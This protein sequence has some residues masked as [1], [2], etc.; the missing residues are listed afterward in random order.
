ML[1]FVAQS[2]I[3]VKIIESLR[4]LALKKIISQVK[5]KKV[6]VIPTQAIID[7]VSGEFKDTQN[8]FAYAEAVNELR[9]KEEEDAVVKKI[10]QDFYYEN[11]SSKK[12]KEWADKVNYVIQLPRSMQTKIWDTITNHRSTKDN[13]HSGNKIKELTSKLNK[14]IALSN[15]FEVKLWFPEESLIL[16]A[17][18]AE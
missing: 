8:G 3:A 2:V 5:E 13:A 1:C 7:S 11:F 18:Q 4:V 17:A 14:K 16:S 12:V 10:C 9:L 6:C 15:G